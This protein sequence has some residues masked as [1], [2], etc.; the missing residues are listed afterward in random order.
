MIAEILKDM[1][2]Y[3]ENDVRRINHAIKVYT[4]A[5][6][7]GENEKVSD[8]NLFIIEIAAILHDIGI[9]ISEEKYNSSSGKY[10]EIEGPGV[11]KE[12][13]KK[14]NLKHK[15]LERVLFLIGNH[16][17]Y[18]K[19]DNIDF[20]ILIEAD[21]IINIYEDKLLKDSIVSIKE[22]YFKTKIGNSYIET[23]YLNNI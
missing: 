7:I 16:H 15:I 14:Y 8:E 9:K 22:K 21:F 3:F 17:S 20:Q 4:I 12:I 2:E 11:A 1:I 18:S 5:K 19:I 13:L 23:M 6:N 10:Q